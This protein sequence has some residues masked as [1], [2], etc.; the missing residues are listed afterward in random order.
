MKKIIATLAAIT[1]MAT[2][3]PLSA[4][5]FNDSQM[6]EIIMLSDELAKVQE[7]NRK[8]REELSRVNRD[9][10]S[11]CSTSATINYILDTNRDCVVDASD[12]SFVLTYYAM[13]STGRTF[14]SY[15]ELH[16]E[17]CGETKGQVLANG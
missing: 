12:A 16:R 1:L 4:T 14:S 11:F 13:T 10:Q 3:A 15:S 9:L 7:E 17:I 5:A 8:L 2:A 6:Q